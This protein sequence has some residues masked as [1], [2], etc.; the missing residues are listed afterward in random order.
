MNPC[1]WKRTIK[2]RYMTEYRQR[3]GKGN[4]VVIL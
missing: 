1:I 4:D 3:N 2:D